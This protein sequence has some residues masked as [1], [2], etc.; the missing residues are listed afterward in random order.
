MNKEQYESTANILRD[1][2]VALIP[3]HP[4]ILDMDNAWDLLKIPDFDCKDL[5]P[6]AFQASWAF[7]AAKRMAGQPHGKETE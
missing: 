5:Q 6:S 1:R 7:N 3:T 4:E 2:I